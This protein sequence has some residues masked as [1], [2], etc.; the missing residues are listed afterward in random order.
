MSRPILLV[1]V[2]LALVA[3]CGP[4]EADRQFATVVPVITGPPDG[5]QFDTY[6]RNAFLQ[7]KLVEGSKRYLVEVE[8]GLEADGTWMPAPPGLN[9]MFSKVNSL[10]I[11]FPGAQPGRWRVWAINE[12][13]VRS[14]PSDWSHF[15]FLK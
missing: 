12:D 6:P 10:Q 2:M 1:F 15:E 4:S 8:L 11:S 9:R 7:W 5:R 14:E 13:N 3:G